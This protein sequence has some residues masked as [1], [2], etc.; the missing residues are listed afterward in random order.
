MEPNA[1]Q[2]IVNRLD[3]QQR[4]IEAVFVS[5]EKTRKYFKWTLIISVAMIVLPMIGL[6]FVIPAFLQTLQ[7]PAGLGL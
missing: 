6:A 7:M 5:V 4:K 2:D 1:L 3:E